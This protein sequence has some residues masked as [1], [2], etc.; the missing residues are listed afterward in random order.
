LA[1]APGAAAN[2]SALGIALR[3][4]PESSASTCARDGC[5]GVGIVI[6]GRGGSGAGDAA[7]CA[8]RVALCAATGCG[9]AKSSSIRPRSPIA[10]TPPHTEQRARTP[11]SGI[12]AGSTRK[13][14]PHSGQTTFIARFSFPRC[15]NAARAQGSGAPTPDSTRS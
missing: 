10:I 1:G 15:A 6:A 12:F 14:D 2:T 5:G 7:L 11:A 9:A 4:M 3:L 13:M 8:D